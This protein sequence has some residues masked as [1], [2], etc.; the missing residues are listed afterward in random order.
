MATHIC[1]CI[2]TF[3]RT[4][5]L[6]DLLVTLSRQRTDG[7]FTLS[8]VVSDNDQ[9]ESARS[10]VESFTALHHRLPVIYCVEPEQNI[11]KA[12]NA[13]IAKAAGDYLAFIDDDELPGEDWL[14]SSLR[15]CTAHHA[16]GVLG[17]VRPDYALPPPL[18]IVRGR[19]FER[20]EHPTGHLLR[21]RDTRTGN[22]L[23]KRCI[24]PS[25]EQPF[26]ESFSNGGED[27][28]FFHRLIAR[29][30]RFV[31][32][33]ESAVL[34]RVPPERCSRRYLLRRALQRGQCERTLTD[35]RGVAKS[36]VAVPLYAFLLPVLLLAGHH[37]FMSYA[38]RLC[39]HAGKLLGLMGLKPAGVKYAQGT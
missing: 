36:L 11:A 17:P 9:D 13:A 24:L 19:F 39:D 31:W 34:E 28:D 14:L 38:I 1:V 30:C 29:G 27:Q 5:S 33:A 10:L 6:A 16:D 15:A 22:V 12:R 18:W 23:L 3:K 2:C 37:H 21:W 20:P 26:R 35:A 32:C 7:E 4:N 8:V 25:G